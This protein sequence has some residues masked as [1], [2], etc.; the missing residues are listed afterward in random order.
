MVCMDSLILSLRYPRSLSLSLILTL[1]HPHTLSHN[2]HSLSHPHSLSFTPTRPDSHSFSLSNPLSL[3]FALSHFLSRPFGF[4]K[5]KTETKKVTPASIKVNKLSD[6]PE[7]TSF[8][9]FV[10]TFRRFCIG[11]FQKTSGPCIG[12]RDQRLKW[13]GHHYQ[14][15]SN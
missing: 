1:S 13:D 9:A 3:I 10:Y 7:G 8:V 6:I 4:P 14:V 11:C 2:C 5:R 12:W 15:K